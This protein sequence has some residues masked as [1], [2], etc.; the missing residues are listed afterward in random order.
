MSNFQLLIIL[1]TVFLNAI[2]QLLLKLGAEKIAENNNGKIYEFSLSSF[3]TVAL[4]PSILL[5]M[6]I[7]IFSAG[8]WIWILS[9]VDISLAYPFVSISFI[10][11]L[12]VGVAYFNEP[13]T[14]AKLSGTLLIIGGCF[15]VSRA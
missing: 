8:V 10:L 1:S 6:F 14:I 9:K 11:T 15:L 4:N 5:G 13:L 7:Y 2:A 12:I 3:L